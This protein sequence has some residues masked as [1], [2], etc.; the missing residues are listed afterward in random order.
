MS[1]PL[2][3]HCTNGVGRTGT[4]IAAI[5]L[6]DEA[7]KQIESGVPID[8]IQISVE[9]TVYKLSLQRFYMC[10]QIPQYE[11]LYRVL[12]LYVN[13]LRHIACSES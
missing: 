2:A 7:E 8:Q 10:A 12:E 5:A 9:E 11:S 4:V 1:G 13:S 6:L 3:V